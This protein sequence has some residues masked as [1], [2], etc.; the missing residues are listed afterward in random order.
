ML[1]MFKLSALPKGRPMTNPSYSCC[2]CT[3]FITLPISAPLKPGYLLAPNYFNSVLLTFAN[4]AL[5]SCNSTF[6]LYNLLSIKL[7]PLRIE[8]CY[9]CAPDQTFCTNFFIPLSYLLPLDF[10][11]FKVRRV[12]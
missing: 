5:P 9:I 6:S 10:E 4:T 1:M 3:G 12:F 2:S 7:Q 8:C 11:P